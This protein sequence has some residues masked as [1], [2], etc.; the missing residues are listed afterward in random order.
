MI[1][2]IALALAV[3]AISTSAAAQSGGKTDWSDLLKPYEAKT[4]PDA[5]PRTQLPKAPSKSALEIGQGSQTSL[6]IEGPFSSVAVGDAEIADVILRSDGMLVV[7]GKKIGSS[8]VIILNNDRV[9]HWVTI[10]VNAAP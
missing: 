5:T 2:R 3:A 1:N 9:L 7:E 8:D 10:N 6:Q 4:K